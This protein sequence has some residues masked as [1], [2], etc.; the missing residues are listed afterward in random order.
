MKP[1]ILIWKRENEETVK[2]RLNSKLGE[3]VS[4]KKVEDR[5]IFGS[6]KNITGTDLSISALRQICGRYSAEI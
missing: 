5:E 6:K 4:E 2:E 3:L 1:A